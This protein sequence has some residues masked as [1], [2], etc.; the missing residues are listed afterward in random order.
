M[1]HTLIKLFR[2]LVFSIGLLVKNPLVVAVAV[3][4]VTP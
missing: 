3:Y 2:N 4:F 1:M